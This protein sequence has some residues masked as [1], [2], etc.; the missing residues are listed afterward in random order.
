MKLAVLLITIFAAIHLLAGIPTSYANSTEAQPRDASAPVDEHAQAVS[1]PQGDRTQDDDSDNGSAGMEPANSTDTAQWMK[2]VLFENIV[3]VIA[4]ALLSGVVAWFALS[5]WRTQHF[6]KEW[7]G[8][9]RFLSEEKNAQFM[10]PAK[11]KDYKNQFSDDEDLVRY[12]MIARL[13]LAFLDDMYFQRSK[14]KLKTWYVGSLN[15]LAGRHWAWY[16]DHPESYAP[17]FRQF[18]DDNVTEKNI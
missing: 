9:V 7:D 12:E 8:L 3:R 1:D 4:L 5:R 10:N 18:L 14:R 11:T 13:C 15:L 16:L 6:T 17:K 2:E